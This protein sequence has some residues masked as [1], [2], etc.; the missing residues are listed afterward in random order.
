MPRK[1]TSQWEFENLFPEENKRQIF[2][3][4][5][6]TR[7]IKKLLEERIGSVWISGE[8]SGLKV[9]SSGHIYFTLKDEGAQIQCVL[10]RGEDVRDREALQDGLK[11]LIKGDLT[12]YEPRGQYQIVV[13]KVE[14]QGVGALQIAFEK[15]KKKLQAEGLFDTA[16]KREIP[17][18]PRR[19]GVAT[20]LDGAAIRDILHV[21]GR[22]FSGLEI[23]IA[24]CR[25]Q[26]EGSALEIAAAIRLLNEYSQKCPEGEG[27][28][29]ILVTRGGGSMEDLWAFN[30]EVVARAV[31]NST[32]PVISA[33]GHE[34]DFTICDF[35]A[36]LR[37]ATPSAAA[38]ILTANYVAAV[39]KIRELYERL[40]RH[41]DIEI[42]NS[43][44]KLRLLL[45]RFLQAHPKKKIEQFWQYLD[46]L[47]VRLRSP[48]RIKLREN[49]QILLSLITRLN[50]LH[51]EDDI[52]ECRNKIKDYHRR[53]ALITW[54]SLHKKQMQF[55]ILNEKLKS[56]SPENVFK[57]G[58]SLTV[59]ISGKPVKSIVDIKE[60]DE[61]R[62]I[63]SDGELNSVVKKICKKDG[64]LSKKQT[65][66][67]I[68]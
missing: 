46:D 19:I 56:L 50:N 52:A 47:S 6:I 20:S 30:E 43:R 66:N 26:G 2:S 49:N 57:R 35:V 44:E 12:V 5:E 45:P 23:I 34:I 27:I 62:T 28:D 8:I 58:Y 38:E 42:S 4:T 65:E 53:L 39:E 41:V 1:T 25:V 40:V 68:S 55:A 51:P 64:S 48:L 60:N 31:F 22:R 9:Q 54:Q 17:K 15:L 10:F 18:Y 37:A 24:P 32:I 11:I 7:H 36:D 59:D 67:T 16:R 33:V 63:L 61:I 29:V 21:V 14:L 13:R 3:V